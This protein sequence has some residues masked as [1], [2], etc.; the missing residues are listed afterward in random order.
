MSKR[1]KCAPSHHPNERILEQTEVF[2]FLMP[3]SVL[4]RYQRF[5]GPCCSHF[6]P[7]DWGSM[8][9]RNTGILTQHYTTSQPE[10]GGNM[11]LW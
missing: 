11:D 3:W 7:E 9:L 2:W 5:G 1:P 6:H 10:D 8:D 4:V